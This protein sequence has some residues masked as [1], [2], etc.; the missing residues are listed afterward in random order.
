MLPTEYSFSQTF[1]VAAYECDPMHRLSLGG[2]LRRTQQIA[3]D[4]CHTLSLDLE[5][6]ERTHTVFLMAKL[7]TDSHAPAYENDAVTLTTWIC[8]P[9]RAVYHRYT[10]LTAANGTLLAEVDARWILVDTQTRRIV[11]RMPEEFPPVFSQMPPIE[12]CTD[13]RKAEAVFCKKEQATF[14]RCD[15]NRHINNTIYADI[16]CDALP[17]GKMLASE[18]S[19][20]AIS[21]HNEVPMDAEF[22]LHCGKIDENTTYFI[23]K[24]DEK[25]FFECE[26][27]LR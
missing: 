10:T 17:T 4:Q 11:R 3:T 6:Y 22:A 9:R 1:T 13:I 26:L 24:S 15:E 19:H 16:V 18:W 23:G 5:L 27:T 25:N 14:S 8:A 7:A 2:L 21:Y 20:F 12:L